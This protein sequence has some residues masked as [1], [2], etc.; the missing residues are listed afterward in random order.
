MKARNVITV[1]GAAALAAITLSLNA[2]EPLRS[3]RAL[4]NEN[5]I[6]PGTVQYMSPATENHKVSGSPRSLDNQPNHVQGT[7]TSANLAARKCAVIGSPRQAENST[8]SC[9]KVAKASCTA[10]LACCRDK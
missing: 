6:V 5:K 8:L 4:D 2:G 10:A 3:P 1:I 7:G 9:C